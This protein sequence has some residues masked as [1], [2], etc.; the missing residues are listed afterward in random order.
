MCVLKL[1]SVPLG[2][3]PIDGIK[4]FENSE[5]HTKIPRKPR[6]IPREREW[7]KFVLTSSR[8]PSRSRILDSRN[9]NDIPA[10]RVT[11][12]PETNE[13]HLLCALNHINVWF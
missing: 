8:S 1:A 2:T 3:L 4:W 6:E 11:G 9:E 13:I 12:I 7:S 5:A 10:Q